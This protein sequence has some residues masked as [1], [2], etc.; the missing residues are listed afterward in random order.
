MLFTRIYDEG[1]A[2]A[3]FVIGCQDTSEALVVDPRREIGVYL[4][5]AE[6]RKLT[7]VA[8]T[9][10][11]IHAD[12][13]S[14]SRDL[15]AATGATL[16]LSEAAG[17]R[18]RYRFPHQ[19]WRGGSE[20]K[21]GNIMIR[22]LHT[23]GHSP[24]HLSFLV[25]D[26]A[27]TTKPLLL[28][29]GDFVFVGDVGRPDLLDIVADDCDARFEGAAS[30]FA[31]LRDIFLA[32]PD[33]VQIWPGHGVS[34]V[35]G[36][37]LDAVASSTVGYERRFAWWSDYLCEDNQQG[38]ITALLAGQSETPHYFA[39]MKRQNR[40]GPALLSKRPELEPYNPHELARALRAG[41]CL[42]DTRPVKDH[43]R[44]ALSGSL[45][46]P[47]GPNLASLAAWLIDPEI[48][49]PP[50]IVLVASAERAA[51]VVDQLS[52]IG[53]DEVVGYA[54][55]LSGLP[56]KPH[57]PLAVKELWTL[58]N[59][60]YLDVRT[61]SEYEAGHIPGAKQFH[62]GQVM[63]HLNELPRDR[64]LVVYCHSGQCSAAVVSGL[65]AAGFDHA[66]DLK[67]GFEGW[68]QRAASTDA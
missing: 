10:T 54:L 63:K 44:G 41:A 56:Q 30:L 49:Q 17:E 29:S 65:R 53:I 37:A 9:E 33:D 60:L 57:E 40:D 47:E 61:L 62:A 48:D 18:W 55:S 64:P 32:L 1:L 25:T 26:A 27:R 7:I 11:H 4:Q 43:A 66:V 2:Q 68:R 3:S 14:G 19:G 50:H 59:P 38:F 42:I 58:A 13:L 46:L 67:G 31:S 39:R 22:V 28:L 12:Y 34:S 6:R 51:A 35:C 5:E 52:S 16:Y 15:A 24:E 20:L 23:P 8:V 21:L 36:K 45:H